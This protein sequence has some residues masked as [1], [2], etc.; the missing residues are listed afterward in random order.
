MAEHRNEMTL[1]DV[2]WLLQLFEENGIPLVIDGGWAIDAVVGRQT[3]PHGDIDIVVE[4]KD[5]PRIRAMLT[6]HG[7]HDVPRDDSWECNFVLGDNAGREV[8][9]HSC[10]FDE[11]GQIVYGVPYPFAS[12][13]G[14]G[15]LGGRRVACVPAH[16]L[17]D[18]H[19]GYELDD[20]D[21]QDV[22]VICAH[23]GVPL[24]A[25]YASFVAQD[26]KATPETTAAT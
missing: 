10:T 21:Y 6:A 15:V 1:D 8:D 12:L 3:R 23:L 2:L 22:K 18:F 20:K 4:H 7:F 14:A 17:L 5:V 24:P 19:T 16:W 26:D 13:Q 25:E 9:V 11:A